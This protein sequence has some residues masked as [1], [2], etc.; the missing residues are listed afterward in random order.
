MLYYKNF[1]TQIE[2]F[3]QIEEKI[4]E[5]G[6]LIELLHNE[7]SYSG[8]TKQAK[9]LPVWHACSKWSKNYKLANY[10]YHLVN[11]I[12]KWSQ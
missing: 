2:H 6:S 4:W 12:A 7:N 5:V 10:C 11:V 1:S 9:G 3:I 8:R